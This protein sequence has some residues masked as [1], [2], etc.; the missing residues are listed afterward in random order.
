MTNEQM[1]EH[2]Q[3]GTLD[4]DMAIDFALDRLDDM[5]EVM[6]GARP[7]RSGGTPPHVLLVGRV[8]T[9]VDYGV[10]VKRANSAAIATDLL[11]SKVEE[12][13]SAARDKV[14]KA[15]VKARAA[16]H[17]LLNAKGALEAALQHLNDPDV[18]RVVA[19]ATKIERGEA[20]AAAVRASQALTGD[21]S[22]GD[23]DKVHRALLAALEAWEQ[24]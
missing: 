21:E 18:S 13:T 16:N 5:F 10:F 15:E 4:K 2:V 8:P 20:L 7:G 19:L 6:N 12:E 17:V 23:A 11:R 24:A 9:L 14:W 1:I 22:M 3:A